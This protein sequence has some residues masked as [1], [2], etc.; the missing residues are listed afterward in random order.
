MDQLIILIHEIMLLLY[1]A[2]GL[3][4]IIKIIMVINKKGF[5][6]PSIIISFFRIYGKAER[7][8][9]RNKKRLKYMQY[10]NWLNYLIY[11][12]L[13]LFVIMLAIY[14]QNIF[15]Y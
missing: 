4:I 13:V 14:Q 12:T 2:S 3:A 15:K 1:V 8:H 10:N 11:T 7:M 5:D 6:L 9:D